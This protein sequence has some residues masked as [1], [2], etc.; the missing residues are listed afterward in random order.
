MRSQKI[1]NRKGF[2]LVEL[3]TVVII[4]GI[5]SG[6]FY[7]VFA[8]N[9]KA[10]DGFM[11]RA[12]LWQEINV[13][14]DDMR[15]YGRQSA[16]MTITNSG[17]TKSVVL[18]GLDGLMTATY[19]MDQNGEFRVIDKIGRNEVLSR[20]V[21]FAKSQFGSDVHALEVEV[22]LIDDNFGQK[23]HAR[24]STEIFLRN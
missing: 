10:M 5:A 13:I 14:L 16:S 21:D 8:L 23:I 12:N 9:W 6:I 2:T 17:T 19:S 11:S 7:S 20:N 22:A 1:S 15:F 24:S 18:T 3:L 4:I